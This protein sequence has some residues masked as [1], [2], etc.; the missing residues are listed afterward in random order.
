MRQRIAQDLAAKNLPQIPYVVLSVEELDH[1]I[2]LV[3]LNYPLDAVAATL[4]AEN[5][6]DPLQQYAPALKGSRAISQF[7][8]D[9]GHRFMEEAVSGR[10]GAQHPPMER[11]AAG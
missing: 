6:F 3:E 2:R 7:I 1:V 11:P 4:A 9:K 5:S 8:Y 10:I